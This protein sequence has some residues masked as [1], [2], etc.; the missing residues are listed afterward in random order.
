MQYRDL[1]EK[2]DILRS[3][4]N[5]LFKSLGRKF[6]PSDLTEFFLNS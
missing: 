2:Y 1:N 5:I 3:L 4:L 6:D